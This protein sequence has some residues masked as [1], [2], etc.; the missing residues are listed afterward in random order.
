MAETCPWRG[1]RDVRVDKVGLEVKG[2]E[3]KGG[4]GA[5]WFASNI[6]PGTNGTGN[7]SGVLRNS[8]CPRSQNSE[9]GQIELFTYY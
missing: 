3:L 1:V 5:M 4:T 8:L 6:S 9:K 7:V 2:V